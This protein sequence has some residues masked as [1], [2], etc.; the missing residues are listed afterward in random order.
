M[1]EVATI[2]AYKHSKE[3]ADNFIRFIEITQDLI[4][5]DD[6]MEEEMKFYVSLKSR[7]SF[8]DAVLLFL[9]NK[10]KANLLTFDK[11]LERL[12]KK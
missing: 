11:Q 10:L 1:N 8:T 5:L 9:S 7:I 12:N 2:L 4:S 6:H 3:Q